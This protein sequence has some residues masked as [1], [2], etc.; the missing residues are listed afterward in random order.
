VQTVRDEVLKRE[1]EM[2]QLFLFTF[3]EDDKGA[4][5]VKG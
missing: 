1:L 3:G 4:A 2:R 5:G